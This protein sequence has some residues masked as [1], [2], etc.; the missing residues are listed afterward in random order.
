MNFNFVDLEKTT[1]S[2]S[3]YMQ[4]KGNGVVEQQMLQLRHYRA[5]IDGVVY[6]I[7]PMIKWAELRDDNSTVSQEDY[8]RVTYAVWDSIYRIDV[9][10]IDTFEDAYGLLQQHVNHLYSWL[11]HADSALLER[12][13]ERRKQPNMRE[14]YGITGD[15]AVQ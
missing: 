9:E 12:E 11:K 7:E 15:D 8:G 2:D 3:Y 5:K 4:C 14:M 10:H 1:L 6:R 13:L